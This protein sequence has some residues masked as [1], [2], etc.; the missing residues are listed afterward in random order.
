M[1]SNHEKF[2][3]ECALLVKRETGSDTYFY[4]DMG[5]EYYYC[6]CDIKKHYTR[7]EG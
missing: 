6:E 5:F 1:L 7:D 4:D 3:R 2:E